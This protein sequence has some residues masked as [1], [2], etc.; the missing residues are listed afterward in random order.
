MPIQRL[1]EI[2]QCKKDMQIY[3]GILS[4]LQAWYP[5][6]PLNIPLMSKATA[7]TGK[8]MWTEALEAEY[9]VVKEII[10]KQI[11]LSPYDPQK[12]LCF[13]IDRA[14]MKS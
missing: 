7:G 14:K 8:F 10:T 12:K 9:L 1:D 3:C 4:S 11:R 2:G 5:N 13:I 6:L